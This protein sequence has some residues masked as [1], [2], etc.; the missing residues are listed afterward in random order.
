MSLPVRQFRRALVLLVLVTASLGQ[1]V[2]PAPASAAVSP[3]DQRYNSDAQVRKVVGPPVGAEFSVAGG[4]Q[5]DYKWGSLY[6]SAATGVHEVHGAIWWSYKGRGGPGALGFP[7]TDE[8]GVYL[9]YAENVTGAANRFQKGELVWA[10]ETNKVHW[11]GSAISTEWNRAVYPFLGMP[12]GSERAAKSGVMVPFSSGAIYSNS[13]G[14]HSLHDGYPGGSNGIWPKYVKLGT[15]KGFLGVPTKDEQGIARTASYSDGRLQVFAG[16]R[17]YQR[18]AMLGLDGAADEAYEVHGAILWR[19]LN[20]G[21]L[22][23]YGYPV[24]DE[25]ATTGG[26]ISHFEKAS[27]FW[28]ASTQKTSIRTP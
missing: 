4:R 22:A 18:G 7:T 17:I 14:V 6:Y 20:D 5:R 26:R 27:I 3:I 9:K 16:G 23:R 24:S 15:D 28:D 19:F 12:A 2:L 25:Q 11:L 21:G 10:K 13:T 8:E 1:V